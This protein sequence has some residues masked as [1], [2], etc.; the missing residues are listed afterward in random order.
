[1]TDDNHPDYWMVGYERC[2]AREPVLTNF[3]TSR[4]RFQPIEF[5]RLERKQLELV[6]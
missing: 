2:K 3:V 6:A 4:K 1:M 5:P